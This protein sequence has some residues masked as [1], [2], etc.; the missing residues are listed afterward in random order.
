M[1]AFESVEP[2]AV[3]TPRNLTARRV[4]AIVAL[5]AAYLC[6]T[7]ID[8]FAQRCQPRRKLPVVVL[9]TLVP[10]EFNPGP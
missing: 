10:C 5:A 9:T 4:I 2:V 3:R 1:R 8:A 7:T 6:V